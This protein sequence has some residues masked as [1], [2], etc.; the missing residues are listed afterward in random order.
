MKAGIG[1]AIHSVRWNA[2]VTFAIVQV[3]AL[4][5]TIWRPSDISAVVKALW[6]SAALD[7]LVSS[8]IL[9]ALKNRKGV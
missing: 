2:I 7:C 8:A 5:I 3:I 1:Y 9:V 4:Y 6:Y